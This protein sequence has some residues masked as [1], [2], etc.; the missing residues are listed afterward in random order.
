M[1]YG[2]RCQG[3]DARFTIYIAEGDNL[4]FRLDQVSGRLIG[5]YEFS[6]GQ[7][8]SVATWFDVDNRPGPNV[9]ED[10]RNHAI[11]LSK[12]KPSLLGLNGRYYRRVQPNQPPLSWSFSFLMFTL[13]AQ[14]TVTWNENFIVKCSKADFF[15]S[16]DWR[17]SFDANILLAW[18][19][20]KTYADHSNEPDNSSRSMA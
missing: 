1:D 2:E 14:G 11:P 12:R 13:N 10:K 15:D 3:L 7:K 9:P 8:P 6:D 18:N 17:G 5:F 16:P 20:D 4:H 19:Q